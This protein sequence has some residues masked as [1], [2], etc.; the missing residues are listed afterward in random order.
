MP[1]WICRT[2]PVLIACITLGYLLTGC[3]TPAGNAA[4][5]ALKTGVSVY[6]AK[7]QDGRALARTVV[8]GELYPNRIEIHCAGDAK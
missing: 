2:V 5:G 4:M 7:D 3:I 6:C 8:A 1:S